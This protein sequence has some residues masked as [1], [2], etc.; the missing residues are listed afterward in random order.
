VLLALF[1][2][3]VFSYVVVKPLSAERHASIAA[4]THQ[5]FQVFNDEIVVRAALL[6]LLLRVFP[7]P[8]VAILGTALVFALGHHFLYGLNGIAI[9]W[10]ALVTVFSFGA[11]ANCWF[12]RYRHIGYGLALHYAWNFDRFSTAYYLHGSRLS[13]GA[14]FN[15]IEGNACVAAAAFATFGVVFYRYWMFERSTQSGT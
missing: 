2:H 3:V 15:Y 10:Q 6:T 14:T 9:D 7:R 11:I 12:V 4:Q 8:R 5:F 1:S 13:E